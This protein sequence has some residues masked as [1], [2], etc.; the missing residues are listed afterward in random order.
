[1]P[2]FWFVAGSLATLALVLLAQPWLRTLPTLSPLKAA[3]AATVLLLVTFGLHRVMV[4]GATP[5][6][7]PASVPSTSSASAPPAA[8]SATAKAFEAASSS[9]GVPARNSAGSMD[10]A[11]A[12]LEARLAKGG[13]SAGDW[14]LLAKSFEFLGRPAD[15]ARAREH[16][17]P[18]RAA[19]SDAGAEG[20]A[21]TRG[22]SLS[23]EVT[24]AAELRGRVSAGQTL[25]V[26]AKAVDDPGMPV[27]VLRSSVSQ[28]PLRFTL[29]DSLAMMPGRGLSNAGRV[30]IEARI[31]QKGQP[32]PAAGDLQG[33]SGIL[34]PG[35]SQPLKIVID[36]VIS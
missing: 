13:G 16:H 5:T 7:S 17:L 31:S 14:E 11:V 23:G 10:S 29:D 25:F 19:A 3:S 35:E 28:W 30:R 18:A 34:A 4:P 24:L 15:A 9:P 36:H 22:A 33:T 6:P 21:S 20:A 27:A 32:L 12:N 2:T 1:M 26:I 8:F